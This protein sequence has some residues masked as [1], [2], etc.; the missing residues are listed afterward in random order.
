MLHSIPKI[1]VSAQVSCSDTSSVAIQHIQKSWC[2]VLSCL[3]LNYSMK[4]ALKILPIC[5]GSAS[6]GG[7][8][9]RLKKRVL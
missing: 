3:V 6:E 1:I 2:N 5:T 4:N 9:F 7:N 8:V